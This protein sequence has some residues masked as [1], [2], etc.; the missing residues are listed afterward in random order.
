MTNGNLLGIFHNFFP[1]YLTPRKPIKL[2]SLRGN[3]AKTIQYLVKGRGE[4]NITYDSVKGG[5]ASTK[6]NLR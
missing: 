2:L 6:V 5:E 1:H 4:I 3:W